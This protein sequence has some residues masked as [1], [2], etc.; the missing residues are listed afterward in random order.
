[1]RA[2]SRQ[3]CI[4]CPSP[5]DSDEDVFPEWLLKTVGQDAMILHR[6][7][8][9]SKKTDSLRVK[10]RIVCQTCNNEWMSRIEEATK[11]VLQPMLGGESVT[12]GRVEQEHLARWAVKVSMLVEHLHGKPDDEMYWTESERA[13]FANP[14]HARP[15]KETQVFLGT[16]T[17]KAWTAR[18]DGGRRLPNDASENSGQPLGA[19]L[20]GAG[21]GNR[22]DARHEPHP[23]S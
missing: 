16:Y 4:F 12:L 18:L 11:P 5:A 19:R 22:V 9:Q 6:T 23:G 13:A 3:K 10:A 15:S 7:G 1:M 8:K 2:P 17:G 20:P 14:P 21:A